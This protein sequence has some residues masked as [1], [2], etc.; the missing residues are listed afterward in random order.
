MSS[1]GKHPVII[2]IVGGFSN[3]VGTTPWDPAT[4]DNDQS[5]S[6]FHLAGVETMYPSLR[7]GNNNPGYLETCYGEV[8]DVIAAAQY[9]AKQPDVDAGRIYLG[10]H[11]TGGTLALLTAES[12][13]MFRAVFAFGPVDDTANYGA[14]SVSYDVNDE[15]EV[16]L[17]APKN[18][19]GAVT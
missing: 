16:R 17:R 13:G 11:S 5:G 14:D 6:A 7:G 3:E 1:N 8:D 10:G 18:F 4:P 15:N 12:T 2:W 19:L 9:L